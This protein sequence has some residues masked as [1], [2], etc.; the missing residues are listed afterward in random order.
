MNQIDLQGRTAVV[1]GGA[2]GIGRAVVER[3]VASGAQVEIWDVDGALASEAA[4]EIGSQVTGRG[5]DVTDA[6]AVAAAAG[7][8]DRID[9]LVT[10]AGIA[11]RNAKT[12][13]Y[14]L[15]EWARVMR[16]N[17]DGTFHCCRAVVPTMLRHGYGRIVMV[18]SIAGKEGNPNASA[19]SASKAAVIGL[20]KSLGKELASHDIAV[21]CI[22][23]AAARTRIFEQITQEHIDFMLSKIP[24][25][26]FLETKEV[27][28]MVAWLSSA[29][30]SFTTGAVFDLSG[31]RATY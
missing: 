17:V 8:H 3:F 26:R 28:N 19:Y 6:D 24:R 10:S 25:G 23:P 29:E 16:I 14:P 31:G 2:Q 15:D 20:T 4:R 9:I 22:T 12:W 30:N 1:T 27:A 5:V 18:A 7:A 21:N 13:E 11:G